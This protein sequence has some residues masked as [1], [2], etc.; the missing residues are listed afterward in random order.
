MGFVQAIS[1]YFGRREGQTLSDFQKEISALTHKDKL[2]LQ[3]MLAAALGETVDAPAP[4][5]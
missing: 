4:P 3:P 5:K 1:K 2:D